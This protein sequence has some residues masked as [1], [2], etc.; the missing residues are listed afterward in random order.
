VGRN[1][2]AEAGVEGPNAAATIDGFVLPESGPF[3]IIAAGASIRD[4]GAYS[5]TL[6]SQGDVT[7]SN[8]QVVGLLGDGDVVTGLVETRL[9]EEWLF[10]GCIND[11][12]AVK[13]ESNDFAPFVAV[14]LP[15]A[16]ENLVEMSGG[17]GVAIVEDLI[18]PASGEYLVMAAGANIRDRGTYTLTFTVLDRAR[19]APTPTA[20][21]TGT[22][23]PQPT[24][25]STPQPPPTPTPSGGG[26][27]G[28]GNQQPLCVVV[29]NLLNLRPG[30]GTGYHPPIGAL[31]REAV[32]IPLNRNSNS[33]WIR[34]QV[35][36]NGPIGWVSAAP[37]YIA[38]N[39]NIGHLPIGVIPPTYTPSPTATYQTVTYTPTPTGTYETPT[40]TPTYTPTP[41]GTYETPT[42]TPTPTGTYETPTYTPTPT[43]TVTPTDTPTATPTDNYTPTYTPTPTDT[44]TP[45]PT[46]TEEYTP[47]PTPTSLAL[48][49]AIVQTGAGHNNDTVSGALI[50]QVTA[51]DP[52]VGNNDGNGIDYVQMRIYEGGDLVY[53]RQENNAAYCAF[54]GGEPDCVV[55]YF[56]DNDNEWPGGEDIHTGTHTLWARVRAESGQELILERQITISN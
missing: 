13:V 12:V 31:A 41:T 8:E 3:T 49:A 9:G 35:V 51:Y 36:P 33:T 29:A 26:S 37:Q 46:A 6:E 5:L 38:C 11:V 30:P 45:T 2:L 47:T 25:T 18:L 32:V 40:Y 34:V 4:R 56:H 20:T 22:I 55:W 43:D 39:I 1:S 19:P 48:Y 15:G 7:A 16:D 23:T 27:Q 42:Y 54:S 52:N 14:R 24:A 17:G 21:P 50:F 44:P 28:N 53:E 10:R